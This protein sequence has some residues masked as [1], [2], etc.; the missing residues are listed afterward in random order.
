[1]TLNPMI[2]G[3]KNV[4]LS[5]WLP[6]HASLRANSRATLGM[7]VKKVLFVDIEKDMV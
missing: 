5:L 3:E 6:Q 7:K 1:M 4:M 2:L